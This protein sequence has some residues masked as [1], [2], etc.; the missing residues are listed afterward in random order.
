MTKPV[1]QI[2]KFRAIFVPSTVLAGLAVGRRKAEYMESGGGHMC[3]F[4]LRYKPR[5][6]DRAARN[7]LLLLQHKFSE[8]AST[9][10]I[11]RT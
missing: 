8:A 1:A 10:W 3:R 11:L 5:G 9:L 4:I 7:R 6:A 2:T